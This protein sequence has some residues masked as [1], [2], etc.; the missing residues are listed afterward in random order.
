MLEQEKYHLKVFD[1][2]IKRNAVRPSLLRGLWCMAG[3]ALG[4]STAALSKEAAMA[5]TEAVETT[6]GQHYNK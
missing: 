6:I 1:E 3:Y 5:C 2:L 4:V